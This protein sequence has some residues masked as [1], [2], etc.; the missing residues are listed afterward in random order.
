MK[1]GN[2]R[3]VR[4]GDG[5][6]GQTQTVRNESKGPDFVGAATAI[7]LAVD[8]ATLPSVF[9]QL[10]EAKIHVQLHMAVEQHQ[11]R[12]VCN[13]IDSGRTAAVYADH[14]LHQTCHRFACAPQKLRPISTV[15]PQSLSRSG[16]AGAPVA[17]A[18]ALCML[19]MRL[20]HSVSAT[21]SEFGRWPQPKCSRNC[22]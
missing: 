2:P 20:I 8:A 9:Q 6:K 16:S 4:G 14:I 7:G 12:I 11:P 18:G 10:H 19:S 13:K 21:S 5:G 1:R 17:F 3:P 22:S 15:D